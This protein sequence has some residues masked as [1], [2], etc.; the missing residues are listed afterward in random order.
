MR[1]EDTKGIIRMGKAR[2]L[3]GSK[4]QHKNQL[5]SGMEL[6]RDDGGLSA[7][8]F[9]PASRH[10]NIELCPRRD[11]HESPSSKIPRTNKHRKEGGHGRGVEPKPRWVNDW[12]E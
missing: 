4:E 2:R 11:G 12:Q 6:G 1:L 7:S 8:H 10:R 5:R 9:S 3:G